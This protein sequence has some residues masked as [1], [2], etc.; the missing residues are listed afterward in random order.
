MCMD[1]LDFLKSA[2]KDYK[3]YG[4]CLRWLQ[5]YEAAKAWFTGNAGKP[6]LDFIQDNGYRVTVRETGAIFTLGQVQFQRI[7]GPE[8]MWRVKH[9]YD[10]LSTNPDVTCV[11]RQD[12]L[13][14]I[15]IYEGKD[16]DFLAL[17]RD[18][19]VAAE[20]LGQAQADFEGYLEAR[21]ISIN[22]GAD[23]D[24]AVFEEGMIKASFLQ[25]VYFGD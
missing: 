22:G 3:S 8:S 12:V 24:E 14:L 10:V 23:I 21:E 11:D 16:S 2:V 19:R 5:D 4:W 18:Y 7:A 1:Q 13:K 20:K 9:W 17:L 25:P 6:V 15:D